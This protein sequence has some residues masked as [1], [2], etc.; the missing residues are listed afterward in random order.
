MTS[1]MIWPEKKIVSE[2]KLV[3]LYLET[4][5]DGEL[6][7]KHLRAKTVEEIAVVLTDVGRITVWSST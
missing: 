1:Y 7:P 2:D 3:A 6:E 5:R 4:L